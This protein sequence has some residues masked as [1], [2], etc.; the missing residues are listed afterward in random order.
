MWWLTCYLFFSLGLPAVQHHQIGVLKIVS[1]INIIVIVG[2][3]GFA[4]Y[5]MWNDGRGYDNK[6]YFMLTYAVIG[7]EIFRYVYWIVSLVGLIILK[8]KQHRGHL[9]HLSE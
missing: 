2:F 5:L 3:F 1:G 6:Y 4:F 7:L 9:S 8:V